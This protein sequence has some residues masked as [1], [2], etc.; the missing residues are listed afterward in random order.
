MGENALKSLRQSA[1]DA[2]CMLNIAGVCDG[3]GCVLCHIRLAGTCGMGMKPPDTQATFGCNACHM[4]FDSNGK[5]GLKRMSEDW[6]F[7]ALRGMARTTQW[8][9]D[10]GYLVVV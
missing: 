10:H 9:I 8:W 7:Y 1:G 3:Q 6:L 2:H 5:H 4:H